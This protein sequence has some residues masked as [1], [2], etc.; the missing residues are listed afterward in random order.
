MQTD[1]GRTP[2]EHAE[3]GDFG[4]IGLNGIFLKVFQNRPKRSHL[5]E[6]Q[7]DRHGKFL[8]DKIWATLMKSLHIGT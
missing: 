8:I 3:N 1:F 5:T 2:R 4:E 6:I 7:V